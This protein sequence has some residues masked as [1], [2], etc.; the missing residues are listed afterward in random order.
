MSPRN[1]KPILSKKIQNEC[2]Q[3]VSDAI[4]ENILTLIKKAIYFSI[5]VDATPDKSHVEQI[6]LIIRF[7]LITNM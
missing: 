2:I 6:T 1:S 4:R 5:I 3:L 7:V